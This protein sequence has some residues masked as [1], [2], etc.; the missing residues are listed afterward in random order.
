ML[1]VMRVGCF[2]IVSIDRFRRGFCFSL[3]LNEIAEV[4]KE[5]MRIVLLIR[6][7]LGFEEGG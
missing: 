7:K 1:K 3:I 4:Y 2:W 5:L 6:I